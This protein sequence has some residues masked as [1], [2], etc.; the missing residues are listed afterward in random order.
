VFFGGDMEDKPRVVIV[1]GNRLL[2]ESIARI[3]RKKNDFEIVA[4]L[5][6]CSASWDEIAD[7][8]A[9]V[10]VLDSL[11]FLPRGPA[12]TSRAVAPGSC[13]KCVL[14]AMEDDPNRFLT[15]IR[16]GARGYVLQDA[17]AAD[18]VS[19]IRAVAEGQAV[20]PPVYARV[21]FDLVATQ[22]DDLPNTRRRTRWGLTRREQQL[23]PLIGKGLSNKEIASH[24]KVSEQ[25]V[26][27]HIHRML[28]KL[29]VTDR[30]SVYEAC[31]AQSSTKT[32]ETKYLV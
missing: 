9:D 12:S 11:E 19:A 25:T 14:I 16:R 1:C 27:N 4:T 21:L 18:V 23:I 15:A 13:P 3:L 32:E 6:L 30:L 7:S 31:Q 17:S 22:T 29:G 26:K 5:A 2:K 20:C 10:L 24:L 28:R 8:G